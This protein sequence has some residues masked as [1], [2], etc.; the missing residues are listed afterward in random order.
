MKNKMSGMDTADLDATAVLGA[1]DT[2]RERNRVL[3]ADLGLDAILW[4][5]D[6]GAQPFD[7]MRN[8]LEVFARDVLPRL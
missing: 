7:L 1:P 5:I 8:N 2:V 4:H 3:E 6:Y